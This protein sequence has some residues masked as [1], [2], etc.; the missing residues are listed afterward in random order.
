VSQS[1]AQ[2]KIPKIQ[3]TLQYR[4]PVMLSGGQYG[5]DVIWFISSAA[6]TCTV[7]T[8]FQQPW[9]R[10]TDVNSKDEQHWL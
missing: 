3:S 6:S 8:F 4:V 10:V 7:A 2:L 5:T 9:R 1:K